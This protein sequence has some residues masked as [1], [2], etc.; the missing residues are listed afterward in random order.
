MSRI[1]NFN[2]GP[3]ALPLPVLARAKEELIEFEGSGMSIMEHSH[4]GKVYEA[5]HNEAISLLNELLGIPAGYQILFLQGGASHQFAMIPMN[6]LGAGKSADYVVDGHWGDRAFEEA[7]FYGNPR[8][9]ATSKVGKSYPKVSDAASY[10]LDPNAAYVHITTNNTI[11]GSQQHFIPEVGGVPL[12][13]DMSSDFIWKPFDVS[14]YDFIYAG[15]QKNIGPSGVVVVIAKKE[16]VSQERSDIPTIFR[17][18]TFTD[19]NSLY[20]TPPTFAIYLVHHVLQWVKSI[21]GLPQIE[22]W[23]RE[24]GETLY[25]AIDSEPDYFKCPIEKGSRSYMNVVWRLPNEALEEKFAKESEKAGFSGLK[26]HRSVGGL[27]ASLYNAITV[28]DVNALTAF[29]KEFSAKNRP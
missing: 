14:K 28:E 9:A 4:R 12:F 16:L 20:N 5:L 11:E 22:R 3:A 13:A 29:M 25:N 18:K 26:G 10:S 8:L 21:G 15:A 7:K 2:A 17:Y 24:K 23:N 1:H 19:N 6:F 27:R